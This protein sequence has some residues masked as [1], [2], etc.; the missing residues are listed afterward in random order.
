MI[1]I[2]ENL[3]QNPHIS[4]NPPPHLYH[5]Y[6]YYSAPLPFHQPPKLPP[7]SSQSRPQPSEQS[8]AIKQKEI[9]FNRLDA[10]KARTGRGK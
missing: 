1:F 10:I 6:D 2:Y 5:K 4:H 3:N 8:V 9:I 7:S